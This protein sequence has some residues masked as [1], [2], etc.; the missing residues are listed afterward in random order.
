M[1]DCESERMNDGFI[2]EKNICSTKK[3]KK[4]LLVLFVS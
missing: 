3:M 4:M 1:R 2:F